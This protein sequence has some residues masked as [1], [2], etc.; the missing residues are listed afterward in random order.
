VLVKGGIGDLKVESSPMYGLGLRLAM[1]CLASFVAFFDI[2]Q[3]RS[4]ASADASF[5][6][7]TATST[8]FFTEMMDERGSF[9]LRCTSPLSA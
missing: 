1:T 2:P 8:F 3:A 9:G 5:A 4:R 6:F 7:L